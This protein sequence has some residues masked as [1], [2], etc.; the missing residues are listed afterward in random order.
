MGKKLLMMIRACLLLAAA[1]SI[2]GGCAGHTQWP[3]INTSES[4]TLTPGRWVWAELFSDDSLAARKFYE[5]VFAWQF[6]RFG[7][8]GDAYT[9]IRANGRPIGGIIHY[10]KRAEEQRSANWLGFISA[11]DVH[12]A[13]K[14]A[15][16]AGGRVL[17]EARE[18]AG[19]GEA[20]LLADPDG[21]FFGVIHS[22]SG[23]P[24]DIFPAENSWF[25]HELW[26]HNVDKMA[27]FYQ[28]IGGYTLRPAAKA[29]DKTEVY[30][31][32][33][34]FPRA[35]I[36]PIKERREL[37]STW[38]PYVRVKLLQETIARIKEAG[39]RV[40]AGPSPEFRQGRAA[41]CADPQGAVFGIVQWSAEE[42]E[43]QK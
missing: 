1:L 35:G 8:G 16:D 19:R 3:A 38:L 41:I 28:K 21:A 25:W 33:G 20:A 7:T 15:K 36:V 22:D 42:M 29:T 5:R 23:D 14:M 39:G 30:L 9:L 11:A 37:P 43:G 26:A 12:K 13:Q 27:R 6:E 40:L 32:A 17:M 10:P 24:A 4:Q 34:G 31:M 2:L 18:F